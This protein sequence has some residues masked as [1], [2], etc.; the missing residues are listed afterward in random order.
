M[1]T[2]TPRWI[3]HRHGHTPPHSKCHCVIPIHRGI[4]VRVRGTSWLRFVRWKCWKRKRRSSRWRRGEHR[5]GVE[6]AVF[7]VDLFNSSSSSR[8]ER[9]RIPWQSSTRDA[10]LIQMLPPCLNSD[11]SPARIT[12][13]EMQH[14]MMKFPNCPNLHMFR[15]RMQRS[16]DVVFHRHC[17]F[18]S[19]TLQRRRFRQ[20]HRERHW[21]CRHHR[22]GVWLLRIIWKSWRGWRRM[23]D[24]T[25]L[26][27]QP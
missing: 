1:S 18:R 26:T 8:E 13:V 15:W 11:E 25:C 6:V 10:R 3:W 5:N 19:R 22:K 27:C 24:W 7:C 2:T 14:R 12:L 16:R 23:G 9:Q 21:D 17:L 20:W 4:V